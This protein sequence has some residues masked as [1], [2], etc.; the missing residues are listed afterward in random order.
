[1]GVVVDPALLGVLPVDGVAL[2][3]GPEEGLVVCGEVETFGSGFSLVVDVA[4]GGGQ[5]GNRLA[6][7]SSC[8]CLLASSRVVVGSPA[9]T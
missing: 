5:G 2:A 3:E 9:S 6:L 1:M 8:S 4:R 7:A